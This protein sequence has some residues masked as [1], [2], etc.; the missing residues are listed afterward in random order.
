[1]VAPQK[2]K[3]ALLM[4]VY[5]NN[6]AAAQRFGIMQNDD[7]P[8]NFYSN[9]AWLGLDFKSEVTESK[10]TSNYIDDGIGGV[11]G[12]PNSLLKLWPPVTKLKL[13]PVKVR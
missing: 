13:V 1:M 9:Q 5:S 6:A 11:A 8:T 10:D 7:V 4:M 3:L 12:D 2:S